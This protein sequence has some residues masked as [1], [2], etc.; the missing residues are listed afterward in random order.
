MKKKAK[1]SLKIIFATF[2][3]WERGKRSPTNGMIEPMI[4]VLAPKTKRFILIDQPHPGSDRVIPIIE[5]Y[6]NGKLKKTSQ[7]SLFV[8]W[9]Y[10][11]LAFQ[12]RLHTSI[13]FKIRDFLSVL[14]F[15]L[16]NP[17]AY[18]IFIGLE[19]INTLAGVILKKF[20]FVKTVVYY[21]TDLSLKRYS[22]SLLNKIYLLLDRLAFNNADFVWDVSKEF[23][24]ARIAAG[25]DPKTKK[26]P[27]Y[28]PIGLFSNQLNSRPV[29]KTIPA[30]VVYTGRL[31]KENGPDLAIRALKKVL[32]E[33][34]QA[35]LHI[36][37]DSADSET[38]T[39]RD[40]TDKLSLH[41]K[42]F[43]H[44][45]IP[46]QTE[47]IK[48]LRQFMIGLAPYKAIPSSPRWWADATRVRLYLAA[49]LPV[50][51]TRVPPISK[52]LKQHQSGLVVKDNANQL[53]QA[54]IYL[55]KNRNLYRQMQKNAML[56]ARSRT[57]DKIYSNTL[58]NMGIVL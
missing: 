17:S 41:D 44:G 31:K 9:L 34:P 2:S 48:D 42:V 27:I 29:A 1:N 35:R 25:L 32:R 12:N 8:S 10:P 45:L 51:T 28:V 55:L 6:K 46:N 50:I 15:T 7:S 47:L 33:V 14:D 49:G 40:L 19:S 43:F 23:M 4:Y 57:W 38:Q 58:K 52:E 36:F 26:V 30:S 3:P 54:I 37:S 20:G 16:R 53:A 39:L 24:S 13:V 18:D 11:L 21:V 56:Q 5:V 22:N